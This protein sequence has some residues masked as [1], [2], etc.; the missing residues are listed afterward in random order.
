MVDNILENIIKKLETS[1]SISLQI[2]SK[3]LNDWK[4]LYDRSASEEGRKEA[5]SN[6]VNVSCLEKS[7]AELTLKSNA[8]T[9]SM[10]NKMADDEVV[11]KRESDGEIQR[12]RENSIENLK[13]LLK[14]AQIEFDDMRT[15]VQEKE[16]N[17]RSLLQQTQVEYQC[18]LEEHAISTRNQ[19]HTIKEMT[20]TLQ[21]DEDKLTKLQQH[22]DM[23]DRNL[24]KIKEEEEAIQVTLAKEKAAHQILMNAATHIQRVARGRRGRLEASKVKSKRTG[25]G[26]KKS[27]SNKKEG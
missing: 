4:S 23:V 2:F 12:E 14:K 13:M 17:L 6:D 21:N 1:D 19:E 26:K 3:A 15:R 25:K 11:E 5:A 22:Y 8:I 7:V 27:M 20:K 16:Q 18:L 9:R 24:L 10:E